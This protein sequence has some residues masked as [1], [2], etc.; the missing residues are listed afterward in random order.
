MITSKENV[1]IKTLKTL[2]RD[3]NYLFLDSPKLIDEAFSAG[4]KVEFLIVN[5]EKG[6]MAKNYHC[7]VVE[8]SENVFKNFTSTEKSQGVVA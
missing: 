1:K 8:V 3:K 7:E 2:K 6:I 4:F 5:K